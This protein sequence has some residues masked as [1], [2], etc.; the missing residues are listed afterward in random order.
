P[1]PQPPAQ[2]ATGNS[3]RTMTL[4]APREIPQPDHARADG[5]VA[6]VEAGKGSSTPAAPAPLG[7]S[8]GQHRRGL[9]HW[10]ARFGVWGMAVL[11]VAVG[12]VMLGEFVF[13]RFTQSMTN[14]AFVESH[15]VN[16]S[17]QVEGLVTRVHVEEH[18]R[19]RAGEVTAELDPVPAK[20]ELDLAG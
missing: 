7:G 9:S 12:V 13:F 16:L 11:G 5:N 18:D 15:I 17:A 1:Q 8:V 3:G 10:A 6:A 20:R 4:N 2:D 19:V 14:D